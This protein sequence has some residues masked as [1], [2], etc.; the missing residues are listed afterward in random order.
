VNGI[1]RG[2][3]FNAGQICTAGSRLVVDESIHSELLEKVVARATTL[4]IDHG[5]KDPEMGPLVSQ[6]QRQRVAGFVDRA[7]AAGM[8][9]LTG[10]QPAE[11]PG[12]EDGAFY[13]PTVVD[14]VPRDAEIA[15]EEVFGPVLTVH[16]VSDPDEAVAAAN[17]T[18]F[19]LVAGIYTRD[20]G[21]AM[22]FARDIRAGQVFING[23]LQA[24]DTVPFGGF[25]ESGSGRTK[26]LEA[27]RNYCE[28]KAITTVF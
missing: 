14:Q 26:G 1:V 25:K 21:L 17:D 24:G 23:Y 11:V 7:R 3:F 6:T 12:L 19:G 9:I 5:L 13:Q 8:E 18:R 10:G 2:I 16:T 28:V 27:L 20:I 4:T 15:Q 22:Q